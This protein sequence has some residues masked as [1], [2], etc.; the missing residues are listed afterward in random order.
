MHRLLQ[1]RWFRLMLP[2]VAAA[3]IT[4]LP[5]TPASAAP[6]A[7]G[8]AP[9]VAVVSPL[10][11]LNGNG[12][13]LNDHSGR[14]VGIGAG[15]AG[16]WE[17]TTETDQTWKF[18][19]GNCRLGSCTIVNDLGECLAVN[20]GNISNGQRILGF[21]CSGSDDQYWSYF[22]IDGNRENFINL[23]GTKTHNGDYYVLAVDSIR[24]DN[25]APVVLWKWNGSLD[26]H[27]TWEF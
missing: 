8:K 14:C 9:R 12:R 23:K 19:T 4:A 18:D 13:I 24:T 5:A 1:A 22:T 17:C 2:V 7:A 11:T 21:H 15:L 27:W 10:T 25:G 6:A 16:I 20:G 26:Q 3:L